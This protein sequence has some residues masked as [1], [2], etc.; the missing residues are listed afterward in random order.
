MIVIIFCFG[1]VSMVWLRQRRRIRQRRRRSRKLAR[2]IRSES[3]YR[4][5]EEELGAVVSALTT[6]LLMTTT[7][8]RRSV[9]VRN[10]SQA[11]VDIISAWD[12]EE[13]KRN[14]RV[15][16]ATFR[17]LCN[18]L[19]T[20]LQHES[21][22]RET[23]LVEKRVAIAL[24]RLGT[25]VEYRT[26]SHLFG[27]GISTACNIVHEVCKA[28]VD[29]LLQRY[30][31]I[32]VG[33]DAMDIVRGFEEKWGFPQCFGAV[34]GSHIPILP[35]HDSPTDY[36][37]RKGFHSIVA[38][39]LVDHQYRFLNVFVG[40]PGSVHDARILSNS[41][42]FVKGQSG[43]LAPS[44]VRVLG[45]VPV[46]VVILG[47]PAYPLLPW[48]MKPYPGTGLG[49]KEKKFNTRLS[50]AHVV[51]E[52]AFGRLKGRWRSLLKRNDVR[53][54]SMTTL[55]TACCILHN[56]CEV[57]Q[58]SFD[59]HWLDEEVQ[60]SFTTPTTA[61]TNTS[62]ATALAIRHALCDYIDSH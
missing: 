34:D 44:T 11:F 42:V 31:K 40:W 28:T 16:R 36:Y 58:D 6:D 49:L 24:W 46:P 56:V 8:Q 13:W 48:L 12:D 7:V 20:K 35:P 52:C 26:I 43:T 59:D 22:I 54:E 61:S 55:I 17:Y 9:W 33:T 2:R 51:V 41:E 39:A 10:R 50:R 60:D 32:P 53:I 38:Q 30:V 1:L 18:E 45:G 27:V 5:Q 29:T 47:D 19:R 62:S 15:S 14:F 23:V 57:H 21:T 4:T 25:N 37:N 3:F